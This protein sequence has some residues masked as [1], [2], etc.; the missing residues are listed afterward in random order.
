MFLKPTLIAVDAPFTEISKVY[1]FGFSAFQDLTL[2]IVLVKL[3]VFVP[4]FKLA[5]LFSI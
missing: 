2:G 3:M 1:R 5:T 4:R